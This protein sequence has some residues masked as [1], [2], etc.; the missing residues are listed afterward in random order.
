MLSSL[1]MSCCFGV[2]VFVC[3]SMATKSGE[4]MLRSDGGSSFSYQ[5]IQSSF[6]VLQVVYF[7]K[8][9]FIRIGGLIF[10]LVLLV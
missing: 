2:A 10:F 9:D 6:F 7:I 3:E 4:I 8:L 1:L 5:N